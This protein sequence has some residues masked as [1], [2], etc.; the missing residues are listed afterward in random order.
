MN[1]CIV[2]SP[3]VHDQTHTYDHFLLDQVQARQQVLAHGR[4]G[5]ESQVGGGWQEGNAAIG[6]ATFVKT[7]HQMEV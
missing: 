2:H 7:S 4:G 5:K 3:S 1:L 6:C